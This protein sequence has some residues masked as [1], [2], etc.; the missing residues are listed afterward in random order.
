MHTRPPKALSRNV[1]N[2]TFPPNRPAATALNETSKRAQ[3]WKKSA[4][5]YAAGLYRCALGAFRELPAKSKV[6]LTAQITKWQKRGKVVQTTVQRR[7]PFRELPASAS[8]S[9]RL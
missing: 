9:T 4:A 6:T 1:S 5:L 2:G 3:E 8:A 7:M